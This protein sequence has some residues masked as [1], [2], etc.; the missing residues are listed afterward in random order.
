MENTKRY[1]T[2]RVFFFGSSVY[3]ASTICFCLFSLSVAIRG[4]E[5]ASVRTDGMEK[6]ALARVATFC[7]AKNAA[8][9]ASVKRMLS[10]C[11]RTALAYVE[12]VSTFSPQSSPSGPI[13][14]NLF[15]VQFL[16][17]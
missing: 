7:T 11:Q 10:A 5:N 8:S 4:P 13:F 3:S 6:S 15:N 1:E 9:S 16:N 12:L 2:Y 14:L 17:L